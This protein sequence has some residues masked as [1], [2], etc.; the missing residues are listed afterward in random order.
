MVREGFNREG[1]MAAKKG[2]EVLLKV[3]FVSKEIFF[4]LA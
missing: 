1:A 2:A 3:V 4:S